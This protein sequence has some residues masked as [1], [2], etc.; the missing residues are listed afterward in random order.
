MP[1]HA[2][3]EVRWETAEAAYRASDESQPITDSAWG[4]WLARHQSFAFQGRHG[5]INLLNERRRGGEDGYWYAYRRQGK[6]VSKQ[7]A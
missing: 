2:Q 5:R 7:Y 3:F 4:T 1:R 6:H